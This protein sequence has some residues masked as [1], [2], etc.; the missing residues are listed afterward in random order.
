MAGAAPAEFEAVAAA[1][2]ADAATRSSTSETATPE[3]LDAPREGRSLQI[4]VT[5]Y[6]RSR[7]HSG[8]KEQS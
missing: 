7:Q 2:E 5:K 4:T 1:L 3:R 6:K 8:R